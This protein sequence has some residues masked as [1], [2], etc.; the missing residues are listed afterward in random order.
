MVRRTVKATMEVSY[1]HETWLLDDGNRPE[2]KALAEEL[3]CHYLAREDN[4]G[5][6]PGNLNNALKHAKAD[7]VA[8]IDCDH[9]P[10]TQ[11]PGRASRLF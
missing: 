10:S 8:V 6:K 4:I 5:A 2:M 7:F 1:P 3:G 9:V 11:L